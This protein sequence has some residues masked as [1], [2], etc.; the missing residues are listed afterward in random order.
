MKNIH[1]TAVIDRR[2]VI[3]DTAH[4]GAY[5]II[6][7][8]VVLDDN[9]VIFPHAC[10]VGCT[11]IGKGTKIHYGSVIGDLPQDVSFDSKIKSYVRIGENNTF[12]ENTT[13]HRSKIENGVTL[14]GNNN[15]FMSCSHVAH[16][17][18]VGNN[19]IFCPSAIIAGH[20]IVE[21]NAFLSGN[22][23]VHQHVRLGKYSLMQG[24]SA[25]SKDLPP[26]MIS[27]TGE[28]NVVVGY[29]VVGIKR[30]AFSALAKR[31]I[32]E[33]YNT[34]YRKDYTISKAVEILKQA[35]GEEIEYIVKF[36]ENSKRGICAKSRSKKAG[37]SEE[38]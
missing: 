5:A 4:V 15:Y 14:I 16:D 2:A 19:V 21:N 37:S 9:V 25:L 38:E 35:D 27:G 31:Q 6:E 18:V 30:A 12:R 26:F 33:A 13:V 3:S 36:V 17:C 10:V 1:P 7:G 28:P 34:L 24:G 23:S 20:V 32:R 22:C 8:E 29:N 11:Q